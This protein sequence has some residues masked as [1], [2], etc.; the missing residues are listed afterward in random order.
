MM[1]MRTDLMELGTRPED[2]CVTPDDF[3]VKLTLCEEHY[4]QLD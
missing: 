1:K 3:T 4:L 2:S